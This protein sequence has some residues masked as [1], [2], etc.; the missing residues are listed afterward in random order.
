MNGRA[1]GPAGS[2]DSSDSRSELKSNSRKSFLWSQATL[3]TAIISLPFLTRALPRAEFALWSQ[4]LTLSGITL[5]SDLGVGSVIVRRSNR[6]P[7]NRHAYYAAAHRFYLT[8][9]A[10]VLL[11]LLI[12]TF[13]PGGLLQP[14]EGV[15]AAPQLTALVVIGTVSSN[16]LL[17]GYR[18]VLISQGELATEWF[19]GAFPAILGTL[20]TVGAALIFHSSL[21]VACVYAGVELSFYY[22]LVRAVRHRT[23]STRTSTFSRGLVDWRGTLLES[24]AVLIVDV[25]PYLTPF[26]HGALIGVMSGPAAVA[27]YLLSLKVAQLIRRFF[28]PLGQSIFVAVCRAEASGDWRVADAVSRLPG[29]V[30]P[31]GIGGALLLVAIGEDLLGLIFGG[32]YGQIFSS[33]TLLVLASSGQTLLLSGLK[34]LQAE[35]RLRAVAPV[36][37]LV[38][39]IHSTLVALFAESFPLIA[40]AAALLGTTLLIEVPAL[41]EILRRSLPDSRVYSASQLRAFLRSSVLLLVSSLAIVACL[42]VDSNLAIY[43]ITLMVT[44]SLFLLHSM[45]RLVEYMRFDGLLKRDG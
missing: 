32:E 15:T 9:G 34:T 31:M 25:L 12:V 14:Y 27:A 37:I 10:L 38:F 30:S 26:A 8:V 13:V 41:L 33:M 44:G 18:V 42:V 4:L 17:R 22:L 24:P 1:A 6:D 2:R 19:F 36:M 16:F 5:L 40:P 29:V 23:T 39:A 28:L 43:R 11:L 3:V 35:G 45:R 21:A 20:M 7:S